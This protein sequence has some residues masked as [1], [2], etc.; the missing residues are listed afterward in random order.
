MFRNILEFVY[1][2]KENK[3]GI[4]DIET[5]G[6]NPDLHLI[7]EVGI[8]ELN[9][10]SGETEVIIESLVKEPTFGVKYKNAWIFK[11]SNMKFEEIDNAPSLSSIK[12]ELQN[13]SENYYLTAFNKSFDFGFLQSRNIYVKHELPDIMEVARDVCKIPRVTGNYKYPNVKEAWDYF[14]PT[15]NY[16]E[17]HRAIDDAIHEAQILF[18][19]FKRGYYKIDFL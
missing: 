11:N 5:T 15:I 1:T 14:F 8:V 2:E 19:M 10:K 18:E 9:L 16:K 3:V 12:S 7:V 13:I 6:I 4:V 17:K